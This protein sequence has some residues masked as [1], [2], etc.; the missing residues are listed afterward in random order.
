MAEQKEPE[1]D[2]GSWTKAD[3]LPQQ[4]KS[5]AAELMTPREAAMH[6][7]RAL[8]RTIELEVIPR[9]I[10]A[11]RDA[12][13]ALAKAA[14]GHHPSERLVSTTPAVPWL[15]EAADVTDLIR[16]VL[17]RDQDAA[18]HFVDAAAANGASLEDIC[19]ELLAPTARKLGEMWED[20]SINF[21]DVSTA[22]WRLQMIISNLAPAFSR[23]ISDQPLMR[24]ILLVP[25]V[26]EH[27]TLGLTMVSAHFRNLGWTVRTEVVTSNEDLAE[28]VRNEWFDVIGFS[29]GGTDRLDELRLSIKGTRD[30]SRNLR[31]GVMVGGPVFLAHPNFVALVGADATGANSTEAASNAEK[32]I[33][34]L[35]KIG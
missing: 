15:P 35:A 21:V 24:R 31:L 6:R 1:M 8:S 32:L 3:A 10:L 7:S 34:F 12:V 22:V 30:S 11:H 29:V 19:S 26:G 25:A 23:P 4:L 17:D 2:L 28:L 27:H 16:L 13:S 33:S 5:A 20:D 9:M 14:A 18:G